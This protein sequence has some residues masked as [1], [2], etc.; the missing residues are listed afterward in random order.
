MTTETQQQVAATILQQLGGNKFIVMTGS[1]NFM[2]GSDE[3]G[4]PYIIM[5]L[6][7]NQSKANRLRITLNSMDTYDM[8]FFKVRMVNYEYKNTT[9]QSFKGYYDDMLQEAFTK[10]TGFY[11]SL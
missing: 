8:E 5:T 2:H 10:V 3:K 9:V 4:N 6:R 7:S 11:T 1:H